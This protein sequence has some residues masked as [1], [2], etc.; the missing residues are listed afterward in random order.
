[1]Q[2]SYRAIVVQQELNNPVGPYYTDYYN[3]THTHTQTHAHT[4]KHTHAHNHT[5]T[6]THTHTHAPHKPVSICIR[7]RIS[8]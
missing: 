8:K 3:D 4:H 1:M 2:G 6:H 7:M 5:L